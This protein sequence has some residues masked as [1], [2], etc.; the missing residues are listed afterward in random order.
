M[1]RVWDLCKLL[2]NPKKVRLM[3]LVCEAERDGIMVKA[4]VAAMKDDGLGIS[5]ISQYLKQAANLGLV[6]R[7][8]KG[9]E[10][11]YFYDTYRA[12]QEVQEIMEMIRA[13]L[14]AGGSLAF[15]KTLR[16]LMNPFRA[17]VAHYL[18]DGKPG[19]VG[20][21]CAAFGCSQAQLFMAMEIGVEDGMF[22][23]SNCAYSLMP[24]T[25]DI[26][27]RIIAQSDFKPLNNPPTD[28]V[29]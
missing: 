20:V 29:I 19:D 27:C 1:N 16:T 15:L 13:R 28:S 14:K 9:N 22:A 2:N 24:Q 12:R 17:K 7:E 3:Q 23:Y 10:V 5:G 8:R 4:L 26:V 25:D 6:R 21:I 11:Y 18:A